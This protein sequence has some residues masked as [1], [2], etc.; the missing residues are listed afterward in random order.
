M[1][2]NVTEFPAL[3]YGAGCL[4]STVTANTAGKRE[5]LEECQQAIGVFTLVRVD[6]RVGPLEIHRTDNTWSTVPGTGE[7]DHID[8]VLVNDSIEVDVGEREAGTRAP[9]PE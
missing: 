2:E 1:G 3:M 6:F 8:V 9:V 4:R 7:E 5:L